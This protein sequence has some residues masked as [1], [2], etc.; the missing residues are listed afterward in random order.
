VT[1]TLPLISPHL[2]PLRPPPTIDSQQPYFLCYLR[3]L[4]RTSSHSS[5]VP[6]VRDD[7]LHD[8]LNVCLFSC[9]FCSSLDDRCAVSCYVDPTSHLLP[10]ATGGMLWIPARAAAG[11]THLTHNLSVFTHASTAH[12][13]IISCCPHHPDSP[14]SPPLNLVAYSCRARSTACRCSSR[15]GTIGELRSIFHFTF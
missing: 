2:R 11:I 15:E 8:P 6:P 9:F 3:K 14:E 1:R 12:R 10:L 5:T 13:L 7:Q 4:L